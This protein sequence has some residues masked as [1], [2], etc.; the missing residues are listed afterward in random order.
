[1]RKLFTFSA[2]V[3]ICFVPPSFG[4]ILA[5][6]DFGDSSSAYT[7]SPAYFNTITS[8]AL[9]LAGSDVDTNG[10]DGV[11]YTDAAGVDHI[12]GQAAAWDDIN[13][14]GSDND[15]A[16]FITL[17]ATGFTG[18]AIRWD[19]KSEEAVSFD[20]AY[21]TSAGGNWTQ[22]AD[23]QTI[24]PGWDTG[25]W[26]SAAVTLPAVLN[27]QPYVELRL[28]DLVEGPGNNRFAI[29]NIEITGVP[30]PASLLLFG[31]GGLILRWRK[32]G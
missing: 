22:V 26:Y 16:L 10:K 13:K 5:I 18:L 28:D 9:T 31:A 15:A 25:T 6:W 29:D 21:R 30:E 4:S 23:N 20:L 7:E 24:T 3:V 12:D 19:Y 11:A 14:S 27:H 32:R 2:C 1:M 17:D 8:P